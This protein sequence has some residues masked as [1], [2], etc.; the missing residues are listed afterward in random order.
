[1][2][3]KPSDED[4]KLFIKNWIENIPKTPLVK[5]FKRE[6][7]DEDKKPI[8]DTTDTLKIGLD[9]LNKKPEEP[10]EEDKNVKPEETD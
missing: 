7:R 2:I 5:Y 6:P 10:G 8:T 3:N 4:K 9:T 1:M